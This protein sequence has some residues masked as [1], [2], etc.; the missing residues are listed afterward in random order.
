MNKAFGRYIVVTVRLFIALEVG[1]IVQ[2]A[3][4]FGHSTISDAHFAGLSPGL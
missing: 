1:R 3:L 2:A 4:A